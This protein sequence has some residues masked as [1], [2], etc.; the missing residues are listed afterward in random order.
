MH[1]LLLSL[2][3]ATA[4]LAAA[5]AA[6]QGHSTPAT[7]RAHYRDN[8][9]TT[10]GARILS[11]NTRID[12]LRDRDAIGRDEARELREAARRLQLRLYGMS[13]REAGDVELGVDR[14]E[15]QV[16]VAADDARWGGHAFNRE[17]GDSFDDSDRYEGPRYE[18]DRPNYSRSGAY[19]GSSVDRWHDPFDRGND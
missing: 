7:G 9:A 4:A 5:P 11:I 14:L 1:K 15:S 10:L 17:A 16:R 6:A 13:R 18:L 12:M 2:L 8:L 3:A 19:T